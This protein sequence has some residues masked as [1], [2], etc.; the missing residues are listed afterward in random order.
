MLIDTPSNVNVGVPIE[1]SCVVVIIILVI[2]KSG[3][4]IVYDR[5]F[6]KVSVITELSKL[7]NHYKFC[8]LWHLEDTHVKLFFKM[9]NNL[10]VI[11]IYM[12]LNH[13]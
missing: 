5:S 2:G 7:L 4:N 13:I 1:A 12:K 8:K 6:V 11:I 10:C 3:I 9:V